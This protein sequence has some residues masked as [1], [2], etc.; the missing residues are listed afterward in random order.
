MSYIALARKYRPHSFKEVVG[1][2]HVLQGLI[3]ALNNNK[4]HHAYLLTGTR[5]VGKTTLAR[6]LAKC[7]NCEISVSATPCGECPA[8]HSIDQGTFVDLIEIDAASRTRVED[9]KE[10]LDNV[11]YMPTQ[12]RYKVYIID[13]VH[14]LSTHSFNALL[15]TLEEPP[16][17]VKF[18]LATTDPQKLPITVLSRCLQL[19]LKNLT[20][21]EIQ[22]Q[23]AH[24]LTLENIEFEAEALPTLAN[25]ANGS[26]RDALS[27]LEQAIA[28]SPERITFENISEMLSAINLNTIIE[29]ANAVIK[30]DV[31]M[32]MNL[33]GRI[34]KSGQSAITA[35][36]LLSELWHNVSLQQILGQSFSGNYPAEAIQGIIESISPQETQLLYQISIK[37][38]NDIIL[39]PS[40]K[41]GFEMALLRMV[42]FIPGSSKKPSTSSDNKQIKTASTQIKTPPQP[43]TDFEQK[44][45]SNMGTWWHDIATKVALKGPAK[46]LVLNSTVS[47]K[48]DKNICLAVAPSFQKLLSGNLKTKI[49]SELQKTLGAHITISFADNNTEKKNLQTEI[50]P[51][52]QQSIT[53]EDHLEKTFQ[54]LTNNPTI[55]ALCQTFNTQV[56]KKNIRFRKEIS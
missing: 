52:E 1:Q 43:A 12:G 8:C 22:S 42:A 41:I 51:A 31:A 30:K 32:L 18:L 10:I 17:H 36:A 25:R 16:Q 46:Q 54:N 20:P 19:H 27:L 6:L 50:T 28:F 26:M 56:E 2:H 15:K 11:Q 9:T 7:L 53:K 49:I 44:K 45:P 34:Q 24:I 39:A 37:S 3:N 33:S 23:I 55:S 5:G 47:H 21:D 35:L 14:M 29:I 40:E 48:T 13:E 38:K 4:L